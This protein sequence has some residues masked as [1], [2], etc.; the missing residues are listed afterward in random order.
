VNVVEWTSRIIKWIY[1][2][3]DAIPGRIQ[4]HVDREYRDIQ[5]QSWETKNEEADERVKEI[6]VKEFPE[7][8]KKLYLEPYEEGSELFEK[9]LR[10]LEMMGSKVKRGAQRRLWE[11]HQ[12]ENYVPSSIQ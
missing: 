9:N 8:Y 12:E 1:H 5:E 11:V 2:Q 3:A 6:F 4:R 10:R 7:L